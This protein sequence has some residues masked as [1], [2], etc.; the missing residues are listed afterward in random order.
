MQH[1]RVAIDTEVVETGTTRTT[2]TVFCYDLTNKEWEVI[3]ITPDGWTIEKAHGIFRRHNAQPQVYPSREYPPDIF[4]R[5]VKLLNVKDEKAKLL[6]KCYI[7]ALFIPEIDKTIL[8]LYG[9]P[10]GAKSTLEEFVRTLADPSSVLTFALPRDISELVQQL[11]HNYV[12]YYDNISRMPYW[13]SDQFCRASTGGGSSKR[14]LFT[15][16][17]D[18]IYN[19]KRCVG[20]NGINLAAA[21]S[22][23]LDRGLIIKVERIDDKDK[24]KKQHIWRE[25][26]QIRPQLLGYIF[27]ILVK[28][29]AMRQTTSIKFEK[30]PRMTDFAE[31]AEMVSRCMGNPDNL[32]LD[33]Y[34]ENIG[35]QTE[36]ILETS[37][38]A[39]A[40]LKLMKDR[41]DWI[42]NR[43][44]LLEE[45]DKIVGDKVSK[46]KYWPKTPSVLS[47]QINEV[48]TNLLEVGISI[49]EGPQDPV[50]RVK[51]IVITKSEDYEK[52]R[53]SRSSLSVRVTTN[54]H[55]SRMYNIRL[56]EKEG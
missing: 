38:V 53:S 29:L 6:I 47:R 49:E 4:D 52:C 41:K 34:Y 46:N 44:D 19:F 40:L 30:L 37:L 56:T 16:D 3:K 50:T 12:V 9:P 36:E 28:F 43:T 21:K 35:L 27:D 15:D 24:R 51:T 10:G 22:D 5:F 45:L 23:L 13:I 48:K 20:F 31:C 33:V 25:F 32:F 7:I 54:V 11:D 14:R 26:E 17:D 2:R 1:L 18:K 55:V 39:S 8:M 42:G